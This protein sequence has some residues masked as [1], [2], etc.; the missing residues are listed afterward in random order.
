M[1]ADDGIERVKLVIVGDG[2]VGKTCLLATFATGDFPE[3][4]VPTVFENTV[5]EVDHRGNPVLLQLWDTAGQEDY[6]RLRPLSY[7][8][9]DVVLVCYS[10]V[11]EGSY[12]AITEK[13]FEELER[14]IKDVPIVL[15]GT[16]V[17]MR[18]EG[19]PDL[20][21]EVCTPISAEQGEELAQEI[22]AK[23]FIE[24]SSKTRHN[25]L[26]LFD[27]AIE[28]GLEHMRADGAAPAEKPQEQAKESSKKSSDKERTLKRRKSDKPGSKIKDGKSKKERKPKE[29]EVKDKDKE[30]KEKKKKRSIFKNK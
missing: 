19:I 2:A 27:Q 30:K 23:A 8:G 18:E 6:D 22:G 28:I 11:N 17:D 15:V 29:K 21:E 16:K 24:T 7:P 26:E 4:Y 10:T 1:D 20:D 12:E 9:S 25:L 3:D 13:W 14:Y 5:K